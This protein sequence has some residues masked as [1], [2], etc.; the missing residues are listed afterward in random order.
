MEEFWGTWNHCTPPSK[1]LNGSN[2]HLFKTGI[3]PKW[4]DPANARGGKWTVPSAKTAKAQ[5][6]EQWLHLMLCV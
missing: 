4:E 3:E 5:L 1:L 6:D 2:Y